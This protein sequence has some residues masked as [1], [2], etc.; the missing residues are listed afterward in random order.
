METAA[1]ELTVPPE[2]PQSLSM[3]SFWP[4]GTFVAG[5]ACMDFILG[6]VQFGMSTNSSNVEDLVAF[7]AT[8]LGIGQY[9]VVIVFGG[10][11]FRHWIVGITASVFIASFLSCSYLCW[12]FTVDLQNAF[13]AAC[14][15][16]LVVI[17]GCMPLFLTRIGMCSA[18]PKGISIFELFA[19]TT[20][21]ASVVSVT[22]LGVMNAVFGEIFFFL[23]VVALISALSITP[24]SLLFFTAKDSRQSTVRF[25]CF[26]FSVSALLCC[27]SILAGVISLLPVVWL[28]ILFATFL[29]GL[30]CMRLSGFHIPSELSSPEERTLPR[31]HIGQ[32]QFL[33]VIVC[34]IAAAFSVNLLF[35]YRKALGSS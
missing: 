27:I 14:L 22:R 6:F 4:L 15:T 26:A 29:L 35:E 11:V 24:A 21:L 12:Q 18:R 7:V 2:Q 33:W 23:I 9:A 32:N 19:I 17:A 3:A 13:S 34:T 31:K 30:H 8:A 25:V 20:Y 28:F 16:P 10:L 5:M 1:S